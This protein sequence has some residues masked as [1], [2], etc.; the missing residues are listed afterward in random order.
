MLPPQL[1]SIRGRD[2]GSG[3]DRGS[4]TC[5]FTPEICRAAANQCDIPGGGGGCVVGPSWGTLPVDK[6]KM[7][8]THGENRLASSPMGLWLAGGVGKAFRVFV[9]SPV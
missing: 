5:L 6:Q 2:L 9:P 4:F 7:W 8:E 1:G 3:Y